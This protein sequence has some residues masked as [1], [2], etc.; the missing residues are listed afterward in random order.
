M[1]VIWDGRIWGDWNPLGGWS[2]Y[3]TC[4]AHPETAADT[5]CHRDRMH[6]SLSWA[7][8]MARTSFWSGSVAAPDYGPCRAKDL[9]WAAPYTGPNT[10]PCPH[11]PVVTAPAGASAVLTGLIRYSGAQVG[12]G[13]TGPVVSALQQAL[14]ITA[15]GTYGPYTADAVVAFQ[16]QHKLAPSGAMDESTWRT[17]LTVENLK[18]VSEQIPA[19][20]SSLTTYASTVLRYGSH[21]AAVT[22]LQK[23]LKVTPANGTFGPKTRAAVVAFQVA[24]KLTPNGIVDALTWHALGA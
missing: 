5:V 14:G 3:S 21:G 12:P 19:P 18:I 24:V 13:D 9:N 7:G 16:T 23:R 1:Y 10:K 22:A 4:A 8:A 15:D 17:L 11:Y 20:T 2:P 6:F